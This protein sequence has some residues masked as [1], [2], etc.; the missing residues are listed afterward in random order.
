MYDFFT[1]WTVTICCLKSLGSRQLYLH[2]G[3]DFLP[4]WID[5]MW[6]F[7]VHLYENFL[8]QIRH[9]WDIFSCTDL[10]CAF[11]PLLHENV[12]LQ[13]VHNCEFF[14]SWTFS[15]CDVRIPFLQNLFPQVEQSW[16]F[17][18]SKTES[19][20]ITNAL[21]CNY[22]QKWTFYLF[23]WLPFMN[24][25]EMVFPSTCLRKAFIAKTTFVQFF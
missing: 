3:K 22:T 13:T 12:L 15:M 16:G 21:I 17:F 20:C 23:W 19:M 6:F 25:F 7:T 9:L 5:S 24:W 11:K 10:I 14:L 4:S 18:P 1:W 2:E 8:T